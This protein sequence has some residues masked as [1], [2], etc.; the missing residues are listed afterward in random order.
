[1]K[2]SIPDFSQANVLV[3]GD[4][5]LDRYWSGPTGRISPEAPVPVTKVETIYHRAGGAGNVGLNIAALGGRAHLIGFVG[6]D[7]S[8]KLLETDLTEQGVNCRFVE[9]SDMPTITKLR[10][11][12]RNQQLLRL[13]FESNFAEA[14]SQALQQHYAQL[15][16]SANVVILSDYGKGTL[17][18]APVLIEL[19]RKS[20]VPV[21][22]DPKGSDFT[23][24]KNAS[25]ITPNQSEFEAVV[26]VCVDET[27]MLLKG[28][29]LRSELNL[30]ALLITRS[31]KGM[32][33]IA[34]NKKPVSIPTRVREVFDV[35]GAGDTVIATMA[36]AV[37]TGESYKNAMHLANLA[38]GVVVGKIGT[39]TASTTELQQAMLKH[40]PLKRGVVSEDELVKIVQQ[41]KASGE[42][43]V[44]T[45]GCFDILHAGHVAY[46]SQAAEMGDRLIVAVNDDDSVK[47]LK[48]P[49]RPVNGIMPRMAVLS[50]LESVDWVV[51]FSEDTPARLVQLLLPDVLVKGGDYQADEIAGGEAV[52][53]NGGEVKVVGFIEGCSTSAIIESIIKKI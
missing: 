28:E 12:S 45:N 11:L 39:A 31:E 32:V 2:L 37:G 51:E 25:L 14:D 4:I 38:A 15:V 49:T 35:T 53:K 46:L 40:A 36:A 18:D 6:N 24:Y 22:V 30:D 44:M 26:G 23:R 41:A 8:A 48:G 43:V 1:M 47:K 19:A 29:Q 17:K 9:E 3:V 20:G 13:D 5:M 34:A 33:L 50:G 10:V 27:D 21:M 42:K 16:K 7:E 52:I